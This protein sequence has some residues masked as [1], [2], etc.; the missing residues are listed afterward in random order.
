MKVLD[1]QCGQAHVFEGWFSGEDDF[2]KQRDA[3]LVECPVCGDATI[4]KRLSAP[5]LNLMVARMPGAAQQ[6]LVSLSGAGS[7]LQDAW[8]AL[9]RRVL[10]ATDD[11]GERFAEEARKRHYGETP[12]TER[13]IRGTASPAEAQALLDEGIAVLPLAL[14]VAFKGQLQ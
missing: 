8:M 11:V 9:A 5:R 14:P 2:L 1:L 12:I 6:E 7:T 4:T 3:G 10:L 13:G